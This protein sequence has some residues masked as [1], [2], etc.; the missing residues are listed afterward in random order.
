MRRSPTPVT[1]ALSRSNIIIALFSN[2][3]NLRSRNKIV[4]GGDRIDRA[5]C[6][7][8]PIHHRS[9]FCLSLVGDSGAEPAGVSPLNRA[10]LDLT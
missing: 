2:I 6:Y 10:L 5:C 3:F 8:R 4:P 1:P 7:L 9:S